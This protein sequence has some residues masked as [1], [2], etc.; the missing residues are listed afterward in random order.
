MILDYRIFPLAYLIS[1][2]YDVITI[3]IH[4]KMKKDCLKRII[5]VSRFIG[6]AWMGM[7]VYVFLIILQ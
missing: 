3:L 1:Y 7:F 4:N 6:I 5:D 2:G